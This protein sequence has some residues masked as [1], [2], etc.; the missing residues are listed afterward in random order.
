MHGLDEKN[1]NSCLFY[2][3][4]RHAT[5]N[6]T[7]GLKESI[8]EWSF[9]L[10]WLK[11]AVITGF[12]HMV[13]LFKKN[14]HD[15]NLIKRKAMVRPNTKI[16]AF[17][18]APQSRLQILQHGMLQEHAPVRKLGLNLP[19]LTTIIKLRYF[20]FFLLCNVYMLLFSR[21]VN[22]H[23]STLPFHHYDS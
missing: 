9:S 12:R 13:F 16:L 17:P 7:L 14:L 23:S 3:G 15:Y 4:Q 6:D 18:S 19:E 22:K 10:L 2:N 20:Y 1:E 11:T 8:N 5:L 21:N